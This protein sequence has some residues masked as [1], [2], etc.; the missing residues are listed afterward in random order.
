MGYIIAG[1]VGGLVVVMITKVLP[2][3]GFIKSLMKLFYSIKDSLFASFCHSF[4]EFKDIAAESKAEYEL[5]KI[6]EAQAKA[7]R[8]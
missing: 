7:E 2:N 3:K 1:I 8:K 6:K 4:E 5:E